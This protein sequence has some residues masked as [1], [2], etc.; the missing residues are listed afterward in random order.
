[1][2]ER[3]HWRSGPILYLFEKCFNRVLKVDWRSH[4]VVILCELSRID[5]SISLFQMY[6][7]F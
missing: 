5:E 4:L 7:D 6:Y 3:Q 1:M 2:V